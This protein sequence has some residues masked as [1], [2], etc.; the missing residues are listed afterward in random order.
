MKT[1]T[2]IYSFARSIATWLALAILATSCATYRTQPYKPSL[3]PVHQY[4]KTYG[5]KH[6]R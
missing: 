6:K 2:I 4:Q 3:N 5:I 1:K